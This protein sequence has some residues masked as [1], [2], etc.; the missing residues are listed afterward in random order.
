MEDKLVLM[1]IMV[2]P[3]VLI[4]ILGIIFINGK[5]SSFIAGYNTMEPEEKKKYDTAALLKFVGK[6]MFGLS[7]SMIFWV[8]SVAYENNWL[9]VF[10]LALFMAILVFM[11][12][13]INTGNRFKKHNKS[14]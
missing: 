5:G 12:I 2:V 8:L 10:G 14:N 11:L 1:I 13:Y 9:F 6:M 3:I 4:V 7:F